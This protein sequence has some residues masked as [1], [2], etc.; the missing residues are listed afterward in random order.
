VRGR[1]SG[2]VSDMIGNGWAL[3]TIKL[4]IAKCVV[5]CFNCHMRRESN[6]R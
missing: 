2:N 3:E 4:E 6:K 1:K 5:V